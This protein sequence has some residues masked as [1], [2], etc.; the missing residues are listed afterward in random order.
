MK[1]SKIF[2][3]IR[4]VINEREDKILLEIDNK[5]NDIYFKDEIIHKCENLPNKI[6]KSIEKGN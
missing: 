1:V 2:T 4:N 6:K 3:Q 5:F